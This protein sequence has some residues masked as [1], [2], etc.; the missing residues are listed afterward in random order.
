MLFEEIINNTM[1]IVREAIDELISTALDKQNHPQDVL[2]I[3]THSF[4]IDNYPKKLLDEHNLSEFAFGPADIGRS[5]ETH[6]E[7]ITWYVDNYQVNREKFLVE[8]KKNNELK[9]LEDLSIN[10]EK[11]IYLKFWEAD[12]IV[13]YFYQLSL[14]CQGLNYDWYFKVPNYSREGSKQDIIRLE[15]RD[16]VKT[17][18]PKFY[19][20]IKETYSPQLRNA[21][22]HSQYLIGSRNIKYL[23]YS[24][25]PKAYS[26][27][28]TLTF[29]E[30]ANYFHNTVLIYN[31]IKERFDK[32]KEMYYQKTLE[33]GFLETR[34][35]KTEKRVLFRKIYLRYG[36]RDWTTHNRN[37]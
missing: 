6:Y 20:L 31:S 1:P 14:L 33:N 37:N 34:I 10:I 30:W 21:I 17:I 23:N 28:K 3:I 26:K 29:D 9:K 18:C 13:K 4:N 19:N 24:D 22:A 2:L 5:E 36:Y 16:K 32:V 35:T 15:I 7:F 11:T 27:I 8:Q 25:N 12:M